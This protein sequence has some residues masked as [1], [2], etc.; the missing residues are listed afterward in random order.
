MP[1]FSITRFEAGLCEGG[2][3]PDVADDVGGWA[4]ALRA[5]ASGNGAEP[6]LAR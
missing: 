4:V 6:L 3:T 2:A 5:A 1:A